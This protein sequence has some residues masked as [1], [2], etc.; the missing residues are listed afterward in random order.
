MLLR[1]RAS[2]P[3]APASFLKL[4]ANGIDEEVGT[5]AYYQELEVNEATPQHSRRGA[6]SF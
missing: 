3:R 2:R 4:T 1:S 6:C 5:F